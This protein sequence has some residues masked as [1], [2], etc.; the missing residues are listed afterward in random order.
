VN[1]RIQEIGVESGGD[2]Y[3]FVCECSA[4]DCL[5]RVTLTRVQYE[6]VRAEG[7]RFF[8]VPGH[9]NVAVEE[10]VETHPTFLV[11]E[12]DGY[13]GIVTDMADPRAGDP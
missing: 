8:V 11:V 3:E 10:I 5:N 1:E 6:N 7:T 9:E 13:A 4:N 12:K 2:D